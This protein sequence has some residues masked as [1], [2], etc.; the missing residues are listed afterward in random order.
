MTVVLQQ[1]SKVY[2]NKK[3]MFILTPT[4]ILVKTSAQMFFL[5]P[6]SHYWTRKLEMIR[7]LIEIN[8]IRDLNELAGLTRPN[9]IWTSTCVKYDYNKCNIREFDK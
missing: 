8:E 9:I 3:L 2:K 7:H 4:Q 1:E 5:C 6:E